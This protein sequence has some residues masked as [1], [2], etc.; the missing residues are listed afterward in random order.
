MVYYAMIIKDSI[1]TDSYVF[2]D[3]SKDEIRNRLNDLAEY[4]AIQCFDECVIQVPEKC[5]GGIGDYYINNAF[6]AP[7]YCAVL[8]DDD[9]CTHITS[10]PPD[11]NDDDVPDDEVQIPINHEVFVGAYFDGDAWDFENKMTAPVLADFTREDMEAAKSLLEKLL[12][13][14]L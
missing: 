11:F 6:V 14:E 9:Y 10:H 13:L 5:Q 2:E 4:G 12:K 8:N 1:V 3:M 7:K